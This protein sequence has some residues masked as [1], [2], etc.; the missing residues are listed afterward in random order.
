[1]RPRC[2]YAP[3]ALHRIVTLF[4]ALSANKNAEIWL[5]KPNHTWPNQTQPNDP[6]IKHEL[7]NEDDLKIEDDLKNKGDLK[8][9][10]DLK[11]ECLRSMYE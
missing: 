1:M 9:E 10:E 7:K 2:D 3:A 6:K 11:Y 8:N 5:T 4:E